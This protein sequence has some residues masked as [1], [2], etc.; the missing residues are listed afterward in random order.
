VCAIQYSIKKPKTKLSI[1]IP[2]RNEEH[3]LPRL[4]K[5]LDTISKH[6]EVL[7]IDS[8]ST[9]NTEEIAKSRTYS[10][11]I[12]S[13]S[14]PGKARNIGISKALYDNIVMLDA[15]TEITNTWYP[16]VCQG[17][18]HFAVVA[19]PSPDPDG[20]Q[21]PRVPVY[22]FNQD[23]TFP[24][25]NIAYKKNLFPMIG[26]LRENMYCA[27]DCEFHYR[28]AKNNIIMFFHPQMKVWHYERP[29]RKQWIKKQIKNGY[30][31]YELE[32]AHPELKHKSQH[33]LSPKRLTQLGLGALGYVKAMTGA[34]GSDKA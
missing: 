9:D 23:I 29:T 4:F 15:D 30:G 28:C 16:A 31:R 17:L 22:A 3:N 21:L 2:T 18:K 26:Y 19:G 7:V 8:D 14:T 6:I 13:K 27:E 34:Q 32:K 33:G 20:K 1:I 25:C 12:K 11:Y 10:R 24:Q 5:S